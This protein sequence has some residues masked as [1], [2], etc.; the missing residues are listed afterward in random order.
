[1][2]LHKEISFENDICAHLAAHGWLYAEGDAA[3][4]DRARALYAPD[5]AAWVQ[6]SQPKAWEAL[7]KSQGA[8]AEATLLDIDKVNDLFEG[9][10]SDD[11][12]LVY[13]NNVI[14]GKLLESDVLAQQAHNNTKEQF[15]N[16]PDLAQELLGAIMDA[17]RAQH[18]EPAGA[19]LDQGPQWDAGRPARTGSVVRGFALASLDPCRGES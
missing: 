12:R 6:A 8:A 4:Y 10:L 13:V 18:D 9:D 19:G 17:G 16:S 3:H 14:K 11:D 15:S 7:V 2:N 5:V 1:M